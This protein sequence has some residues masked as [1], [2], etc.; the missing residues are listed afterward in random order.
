MYIHENISNQ[1]ENN[2]E[3]L[4]KSSDNNKVT[5]YYFTLHIFLYILILMIS[6]S[7]I[8]CIMYQVVNKLMTTSS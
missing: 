3:I 8:V 1:T 6:W 7:D 4:A 5:R 2:N